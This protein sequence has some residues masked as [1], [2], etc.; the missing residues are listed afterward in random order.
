[1][2]QPGKYT[3]ETK[4]LIKAASEVG[5]KAIEENFALGLPVYYWENNKLVELHASG[6][7][8]IIDEPVAA[9]E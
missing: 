7:K 2:V 9:G 6:E 4:K 3:E 8:K 5:P 1:M